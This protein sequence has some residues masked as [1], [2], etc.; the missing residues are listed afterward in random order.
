MELKNKY[1]A[2]V[3]LA[4]S[5]V[6]AIAFLS[7][8]GARIVATDLRPASELND[9]LEK[10]SGMDVKLE[11]GGHPG[12]IFEQADMIVVSPG[13]PKDIGPLLKAKEQG[14]P[15][16]SE[17]ELA[18]RHI[19]APM[20]AV[21]GTNGKSTT[22]ALI[23]EIMKTALGE[24]AVFVG[25]NIGTPITK[26][27]MMDTSIEVA[28]I[29]VSS[30]QLEFADT[31]APRIALMLNISPDHLDRYRDFREYTDTKQKIFANQSNTDFAIVNVD[32]PLAKAMLPS[33]RA[34][35]VTI[36]QCEKP[37]HGMWIN[38]EVLE[39]RSGDGQSGE[40]KVSDVPLHGRHNLMNVMAAACAALA[41][42]VGMDVVRQA[43]RGFS[44]LSHR[45]ELVRETGGIKFYN[46][47]KAT[48]AGAVQAAVT[49]LSEPIILLMGGQ[50]KGCTFSELA[51]NISRRVKQVVTFGESA[52]SIRSDMN[53][54]IKVCAVETI[55]QAVA[56]AKKTAAPGDA[57]LLAP[58]CASFDQFRD[59]GHRG[60]TFKRLVMEIV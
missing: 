33:L 46:D 42:G 38:K 29:E 17:L 55:G 15:I 31:I 24:D 48:N 1:V 10:I 21:T 11:L 4:A 60:E 2:V 57:V 23:G 40:I 12:R 45:L 22:V 52:E 16:L 9:V 44:G 30:F 18:A 54:K 47:S 35:P 53:A 51:R 7:K 39:Y 14:V 58:G 13:V 56:E 43:V 5:G 26:M 32:D 28:V 49:G 36:S 6:A 41:F 27:L 25:G 19:S 20:I 34:R 59:Y 50:A 3:G 8:K 37:A